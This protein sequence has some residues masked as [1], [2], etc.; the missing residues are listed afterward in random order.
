MSQKKHEMPS[1]F[2]DLLFFMK[3]V[4]RSADSTLCTRGGCV[5]QGVQAVED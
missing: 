4:V 5:L 1:V 3:L 2:Y